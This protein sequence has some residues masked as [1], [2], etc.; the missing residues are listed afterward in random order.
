[1]SE[2][3]M[4]RHLSESGRYRIL[5]KLVPRKIASVLRP[6]YPLKG[7]ILDTETTGLNAAK[8]EIIEIGVIA[9]TFDATG[10]I[11]DITALYGGLRQPSLSI[12]AEITRLT[13]ITDDMVA[14]QTLD[15]AALEA[16]IEPADLLIAHNAGFDRPFCEALSPLFSRKA[17]ACSNVQVDWASRGYEGTKLG[18]L[19]GQAG[20]FHDGHRAVDDCFALLEVLARKVEGSESTAFAELYQASQ[21]ASVRIFAQNSPFEMKDHLKARGYRWS[22][23]SDGR[24]KS[25]WI[26]IPDQAL[27]DELHYLRSEVYR[28]T[29][30]DPLIKRLTAFDRFRAACI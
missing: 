19:I 30:A 5:K 7:I 8:D 24:P 26:E 10:G 9:F 21:R 17:W 22:D 13:G 3:D 15:M 12:P 28:Y 27:E 14:G 29:D 16:L 2:D 25:W 1:M 6:Q 4:V 11:G 18:Y 23:G 20:Y